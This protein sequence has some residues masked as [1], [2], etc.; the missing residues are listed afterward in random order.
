MLRSGPMASLGLLAAESKIVTNGGLGP[1]VLV[2]FI[3]EPPG[4]QIC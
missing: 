4:F 2:Q 1:E 3:Q